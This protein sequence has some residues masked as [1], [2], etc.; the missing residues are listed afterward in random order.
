MYRTRVPWAEY[1][2]RCVCFYV[3]TTRCAFSCCASR[4]GLLHTFHPLRGP[5]SRAEPRPSLEIVRLRANR[6]PHQGTAGS[7]WIVSIEP[8]CSVA[9]GGSGAPSVFRLG[10]LRPWPNGRLPRCWGKVAVPRATATT[11]SRV[12]DGARDRPSALPK[13]LDKETPAQ[14]PG[15]R[16]AYTTSALQYRPKHRY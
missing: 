14:R 6:P 1:R 12:L 10:S 9:S 7:H 4:S 3:A 15:L 11:E 16:A 2:Y 8:R 5:G 13:M